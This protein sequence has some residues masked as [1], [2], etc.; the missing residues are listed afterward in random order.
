MEN[1]L[2]FKLIEVPKLFEK[3][4]ELLVLSTHSPKG[5]FSKDNSYIIFKKKMETTKDGNTVKLVL[6]FPHFLWILAN[7]PE[8][9]I[10]RTSKSR[11]FTRSRTSSL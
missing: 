3:L 8:I 5:R 7:Q 2:P 4:L 1:P 11:F 10:T 9:K 6:P